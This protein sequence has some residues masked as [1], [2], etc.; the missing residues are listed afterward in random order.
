MFI[1]THTELFTPL[2][3]VLP[4]ERVRHA[5]T[6]V[7]GA[8]PVM[9]RPYRLS[10]EQKACANEQIRLAMKEGWIQPSTSPWGTAILMVPKKD[11]TWRMCVDYRDLNALTVADAYPL[12][13]IDDLLHR[14]GCAKYFSKLD[15]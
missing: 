2:T 7:P 10:A 11:K 3:G 5:I 15:L 4:D 9:K 1:D 14:L 12:P 6:L 8:L 13:R